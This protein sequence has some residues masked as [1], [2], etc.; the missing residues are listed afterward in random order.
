MTGILDRFAKAQAAFRP[1][2]MDDLLALALAYRLHEE[3]AAAHYAA[4]A[5]EHSPE[6]LVC[7]YRR[8]AK[9]ANPGTLAARFHAELQNGNTR[10]ASS[11]SVM[12]L[13]VKVERRSVAAA[14]FKGRH[15]EDTH[16][17]QLSSVASRA[18][19]SAVGFIHWMLSN[20]EIESA[21]LEC[22]VNVGDVRRVVLTNT[23]QEVCIAP[24][25]ISLWQFPKRDLFR[26]FGYPALRSRKELREVILS[27]WPV[28]RDKGAQNQALDAVALG[29]LVQTERLFLN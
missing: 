20:F 24:R 26:A 25:P 27:M 14:V 18:Q 12:L 22:L 28:L 9:L 16:V 10:R 19:S 29:A 8:A 3:A 4:L 13:S 15:I 21:A 5:S 6:A 7:A 1:T 11:S 17:R 2:T 23:I